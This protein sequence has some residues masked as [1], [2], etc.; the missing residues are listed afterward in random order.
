MINTKS[1]FSML[2]LIN[3]EVTAIKALH[4]DC[5]FHKAGEFVSL[6]FVMMWFS[7]WHRK[8]QAGTEGFF[9]E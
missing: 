1:Q 9:V 7:V 3:C 4:D 2:M 6:V 5:L 8:G